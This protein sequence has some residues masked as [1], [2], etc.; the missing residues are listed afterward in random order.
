MSKKLKWRVSPAPT[1]RY[2]SFERRGWPSADLGERSMVTL[3]C[4]DEYVPADIRSGNHGPIKVHVANRHTD[5]PQ[6]TWR[7]LKQRAT[8]LAEAKE[9]A[10]DFFD[11][12]PKFFGLGED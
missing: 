8:T 3:Y 1:G 7:T 2:R 11:R 5:R 6:F 4:E 9:L 10:Q 12:N